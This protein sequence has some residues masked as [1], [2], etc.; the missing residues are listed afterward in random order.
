[1]GRAVYLAYFLLFQTNAFGNVEQ[2]QSSSSQSLLEMS[3]EDLLN[4]TIKSSTLSD[5]SVRDAPSSVT[6]FTHQ[7][8]KELGVQSV[9]ELL[10]F[11]PGFQSSREIFIGDGYR[12]GVRGTPSPQPSFNVLFLINGKRMNSDLAG[13]AMFENRYM[14]VP[15][16][17]KIEVIRGPGSALYGTNAF[18]GVVNIITKKQSNEFRVAAGNLNSLEAYTNFS[19]ESGEWSYSGFARYYK[20]SGQLYGPD[21]TTPINP[22]AE[23]TR[24]PYT[25]KD[26]TGSISWN[27]TVSFEFRHM[28]RDMEDFFVFRAVEDGL[29]RA[30]TQQDSLSLSYDLRID[31]KWLLESRLVYLSGQLTTTEPLNSVV[32]DY[33]YQSSEWGM[34]VDGHYYPIVDHTLTFG[35]SLRRPGVDV[36][37]F[38]SADNSE[39]ISLGAI[40]HRRFLGL[41]IQDEIRISDTLNATIGLRSDIISEH[42]RNINPRAAIVYTPKVKS[43][44]K[45]IY[46]TAF[47]SPN[48]FQTDDRYLGN[49]ALKAE[50]IE[51]SEI[52]WLQDYYLQSPK[53]FQSVFSIFYSKHKNLVEIVPGEGPFGLQT[54]NSTGNLYSSGLEAEFQA[55][56]SANF[57]A[58]VALTR[59]FNYEHSPQNHPRDTLSFSSTYTLPNGFLNISALYRSQTTQTLTVGELHIGDYWRINTNANWQVTPQLTATLS[60]NNVTNS[61]YYSPSVIETMVKGIENRGRTFMVGLDYTF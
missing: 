29:L 53:Q 23:F 15:N 59:L 18:L 27:S 14:T 19:G 26:V 38:K 56:V 8:I 44:F 55:K 37:Q 40:D 32:G 16:I 49:P 11:V 30:K 12:I 5:I 57:S 46:G 60:I 50:E 2:Q 17:E 20:D 33:A 52:A 51:T 42:D 28:T 22:N 35:L 39:L 36:W 6:V 10:N 58:K 43:T 13:G 48:R 24:D 9:E 25:A 3:L 41:Y 61:R 54:I 7:Q 34:E 45:F 31:D 47:R 4:V 1:M 21:I